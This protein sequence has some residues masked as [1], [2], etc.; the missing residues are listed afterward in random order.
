M[1]KNVI[2]NYKIGFSVSCFIFFSACAGKLSPRQNFDWQLRTTKGRD[3]EQIETSQWQ[4]GFK[5]DLVKLQ[6]LRNGNIDHY[7][8]HRFPQ[9]D[10]VYVLQTEPST[11]RVIS[12][13]IDGDDEACIIVP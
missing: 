10:C 2:C 4:L 8:K 11:H 1:I 7:Y 5:G 13:R 6:I 3:I 12:A 9:G